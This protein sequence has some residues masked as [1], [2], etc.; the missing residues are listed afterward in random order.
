VSVLNEHLNVLGEPGSRS[1]STLQ[2]AATIALTTRLD[3][4]NAVNVGVVDGST[5][6]DTEASRRDVAPLAPFL[7]SAKLGDTALV[8]D[9]ASWEAG[10]LKVRGQRVGVVGLVP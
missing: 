1:R 2:T 8:N 9:E 4:D 6:L 3:P 5:R 7:A 10:F